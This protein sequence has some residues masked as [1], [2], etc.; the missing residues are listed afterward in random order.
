MSTDNIVNLADRRANRP[1]RPIHPDLAAPV[2]DVPA[3]IATGGNLADWLGVFAELD[4]IG[5]Q[6]VALVI[7][8]DETIAGLGIILAAGEAAGWKPTTLQ[9]HPAGG[10]CLGMAIT[11]PTAPGGAS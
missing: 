11:A 6:A 9:T 1:A 4:A 3:G 10:V 2:G 8:A 7:G 5:Q